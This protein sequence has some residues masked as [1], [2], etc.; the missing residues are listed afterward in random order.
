MYFIQMLRI[1]LDK[2]ERLASASKPTENSK[3][4]EKEVD[5]P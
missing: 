4:T 5:I 1:S 3:N 2:L